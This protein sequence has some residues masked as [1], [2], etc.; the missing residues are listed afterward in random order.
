MKVIRANQVQNLWGTARAAAIANVD[1]AAA[2]V[3][4]DGVTLATGDR[5]L[6]T[7]QT[8]PIQNGIWIYT[9]AATNTLARPAHDINLLTG[10]ENTLGAS[11]VVSEGTAYAETLWF[12]S[13]T[14]GGQGGYENT[15]AIIGTDEMEFR[16][17]GI[18]SKELDFNSADLV[19]A[20]NESNAAYTLAAA[21]AAGTVLQIF[22]NGVGLNKGTD[23][24]ISGAVIT[25]TVA[26]QTGDTLTALVLY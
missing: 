19:G 22:S 12:L 1:I 17:V 7:A 8:D 26:P 3:S 21:Y 5:V 15:V 2:P 10:A 6:L 18:L 13:A 23:W 16:R 20:I 25:L 9:D 14:N 24:T 11:C 4:I